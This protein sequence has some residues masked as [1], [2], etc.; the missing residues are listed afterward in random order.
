MVVQDSNTFALD[1]YGRL[2]QQDGNLFFSPYSISNALAMTYAGAGGETATQTAKTMHFTRAE[3]TTDEPHYL[4]QFIGHWSIVRS[5][6]RVLFK[7]SKNEARLDQRP[8][9]A[10]RS[11]IESTLPSANSNSR[12]RS[13]YA[14]EYAW[15]SSKLRRRS[16]L[17][18]T[19]HTFAERGSSS[20]KD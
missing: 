18:C 4:N 19:A 3:T 11:R 16:R 13:G 17:D 7:C 20:K 8:V 15:N 9:V 14:R 5:A 10:Y 1:L 2:T 6:R 12:A